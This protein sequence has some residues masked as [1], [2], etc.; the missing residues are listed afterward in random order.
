MSQIAIF[1]FPQEQEEWVLIK[2]KLPIIERERERERTQHH[3]THYKNTVFTNEHLYTYTPVAAAGHF[4]E[5]KLIF[6][7]KNTK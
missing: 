7:G 6:F 3:Y 4:K 5:R 2:G 1:D